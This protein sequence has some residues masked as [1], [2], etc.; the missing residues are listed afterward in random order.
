MNVGGETAIR[1]VHPLVETTGLESEDAQGPHRQ[2][3]WPGT[4]SAIHRS[5]G[6]KA[7]HL[8]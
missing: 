8:A 2:S 3:T 5:S 4:R 6:I 1:R 7:N